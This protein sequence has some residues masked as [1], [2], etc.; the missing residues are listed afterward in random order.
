MEQAN[1]VQRA[2]ERYLENKE[3]RDNNI[4]DY[5]PFYKTMPR[6]SKYMPGLVGGNYYHITANTS[7][8]KTVL[9]KYMAILTPYIFS[10][11]VMP[12][13]YRIIYFALEESE[14]EFVD[15]LICAVLN[16]A[17]GLD[18]DTMMLNSYREN[19][20]SNDILDKIK[21][22]EKIVV[23]I[24]ERVD[25]QT[26]IL[27]PTGIYKYCRQVS[28][29]LGNHIHK[30]EVFTENPVYSHY[31]PHDDTQVIVVIDNFNL[32]STEKG[33]P[34]LR[35]AMGKMSLDYCR[36]QITKNWKW[37]VLGIVQQAAAGEQEE[38]YKGRSIISKLKPSLYNYGD[39]KTI[40][41]DA[42][43]VMGLF[44]PD[45]HELEEYEGYPIKE[46]RSTFKSLEILKNRLGRVNIEIPLF[47]DHTLGTFSELPSPDNTALLE[48][49]LKKARKIL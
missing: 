46:F 42:H 2:R 45:R 19:P 22:V 11:T 44:G 18:V 49:F 12:I 38:F 20:I 48:N 39:N 31:E 43:I 30:K 28:E 8:G 15:S 5:I 29:Q 16:E 13:N 32:L 17:Y 33:A 21:A 10:K 1:I 25:L 4:I 24:M 26:N 35:D 40:S 37:V 27:N 23:E 9:A 34:T 36:L 14:E 7:V 41:R 3:K 47:F 6:F